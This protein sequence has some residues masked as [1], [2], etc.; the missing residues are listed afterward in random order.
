MGSEEVGNG[1]PTATIW[2]RKSPVLSEATAA[3]EV[4]TEAYACVVMSWLP[5]R[6]W[7]A[8]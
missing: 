1:V 5:E 4:A 3:D 2:W 6:V 7:A 8:V